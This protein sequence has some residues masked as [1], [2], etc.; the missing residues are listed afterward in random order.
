MWGDAIAIIFI[1]AM[2]GLA[3]IVHHWPE[4]PIEQDRPVEREIE[5]TPD[6]PPWF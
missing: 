6:L 3:F 4:G 5:Q 1:A 2:I